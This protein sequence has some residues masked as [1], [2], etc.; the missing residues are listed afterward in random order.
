MAGLRRPACRRAGLQGGPPLRIL[1]VGLAAG[2]FGEVNTVELSLLVDRLRAKI[3]RRALVA[4]ALELAMV[5]A[6]MVV[7]FLIRGGL[8]E[9]VDEAVSR[10]NRIIDVERA[11]GIFWERD[12]QEPVL[13]SRLLMQIANGIYVWGHFPVILATAFWLYWR[14]RE[15]YNFYRTALLVSAF[16]G[17]W[18]YGFFPAAPPRLMP[19]Q[20]G[21]VDTIALIAKET[22]DMQPG[23]FVNQY[24]AVPSL[25]FGWALLAGIAITD[26]TNGFLA[27]V[28][29]VLIPSAMFWAIVVTG[30]HFIFD[31][32]VGGTIVLFS[33]GVSWLF[34]SGRLGTVLRLQRQ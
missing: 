21:F 17:L 12:W 26:T 13:K 24:A 16:I 5:F 8:P 4:F 30:N 15:R 32:L 23:G 19:Q 29:A 11:L 27:K 22:Y 1:T 10:S 18:A 31:M 3:T 2:K 34:H 14:S 33:L 20:W 25:H 6:A 9:P 28:L 7:Y